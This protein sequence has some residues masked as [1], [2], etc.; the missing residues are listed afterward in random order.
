M[1]RS[2][3]AFEWDGGNS[4]RLDPPCHEAHQGR[5]CGECDIHYDTKLGDNTGLCKKCPDST[6]NVLRILGLGVAAV[7]VLFFLVHDS[8]TGI[9]DITKSVAEKTD[10]KVP[11][12]S[13]GIRI[14]SSFMQI[15]GLL[16][17]FRLDLP[18]AVVSLVTAQSSLSGVGG[19]VISFNCLMPTT[20]GSELFMVKII[21]VVVLLPLTLMAG[22][23]LFWLVYG[24]CRVCR[25]KTRSRDGV[26]GPGAKDKM[27]GSILVLYYLTFPSI[28]NGMTEAMSCT[29]Y[30][31]AENELA[32]I[33]LDGALDVECYQEE[34]L[35]MLFSIVVPSFTVFVLFIPILVVISM[36]KLYLKKS[37]LPHQECFNPVACYRYGFL[38]LGYEQEFYGW[39]IVVMLRKA[40]FVVVSGLLRPYGPVSQVVGASCI[41]IL[42]LSIHLQFR[43]YDSDGHDIME[44]VS[45]HTSLFILMGVLL[46]SM[47]GQSLDGSLGPTSSI[48]LSVVVFGS[49]YYFVHVATKHITKHSHE[50]PGLL[51]K[52]A[53]RCS[54]KTHN[55]RR[56]S[57]HHRQA[58]HVQQGS[59]AHFQKVVPLGTKTR[60][61]GAMA[62][63]LTMAVKS[64]LIHH[65]VSKTV[66][67]HDEHLEAHQ[68]KTAVLHQIHAQK[69]KNRLQQRKLRQLMAAQK[70][71]VLKRVASRRKTSEEKISFL[72]EEKKVSVPPRSKVTEI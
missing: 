35:I 69:T 59:T 4:T 28:L 38:F 71:S 44:S 29:R 62:K 1:S 5:F 57:I 64:A 20:R 34:H 27:I 72:S 19:A 41:L 18:D 13:V 65:K 40:A 61:Q 31:P 53:R 66:E 49:T 37:L 39:E 32:K 25:P 67:E 24:L 58:G 10:A 16:N 33:L 55:D 8:L 21:T 15:A 36:H 2:R 3:N 48:I 51:G 56:H 70:K 26:R 30:G 45:L 63:R 43:P 68:K 46:C 17:N 9:S 22:V 52:I 11:F 50:H 54:K 14:V 12:H 60:L 6:E 23:V 47:V 7:L 42:A